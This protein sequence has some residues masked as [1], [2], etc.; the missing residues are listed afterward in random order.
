MKKLYFIMLLF[1][2]V[3]AGCMQKEEESNSGEENNNS[4][5]TIVIEDAS[6]ERS[7][8]GVQEKVVALEWSVAEEL[9]AV[10]VQPA[11]VA[12]VEGFNKWVTIDAKLDESVV[13]IGLRT[14]PNIEEIAKLEPDVIIGME[15]QEQ[16]KADL[17]K[18]APVVIFDS[19]TEEAQ[20][21]LYAYMLHTLKQTGKLVGKEQEADEAVAHLE[22]KMAEA[23]ENISAAQL[24]TNE[25]VFTQAYSANQAPT[26][27][28]FTE[29][30]TVS[31]TL[32]G[33]GLTNKIQDQDPQPSGF[34]T[35][36]VEG[37]SKYEEA[38]FLHTVQKDDP[39]FSNLEGNK[40]WN[41]LYFVEN[42]LMY[43]VGA[44]VWTFGSVLSMETLVDH[45]EE[46]L[47]K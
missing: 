35:T 42:D 45:V 47:V 16:F 12:D 23:K 44:G 15:Y 38:I 41:S 30:S 18:I 4:N 28:L 1:V 31:H 13:D 10:G 8:E 37:V 39:L 11:A 6:G 26:F 33:I 29:N 21:D 46:T 34:I 36:N 32:E 19:S 20:K 27:R 3:L 43:D 2:L 5:Q 40:A 22:E 9:L 7:F 14:E 17:E 25:F 24:K